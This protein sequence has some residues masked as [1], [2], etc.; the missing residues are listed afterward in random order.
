[1]RYGKWPETDWK[2]KSRKTGEILFRLNFRHFR[3]DKKTGSCKLSQRLLGL[4][5]RRRK[6][7]P[8]ADRRVHSSNPRNNCGTHFGSSS[9]RVPKVTNWLYRHKKDCVHLNFFIATEKVLVIVRWKFLL[10]GDHDKFNSIVRYLHKL[11][12][13]TSNSHRQSKLYLTRELVF[14][15]PLKLS[16]YFAENKKIKETTLFPQKF[17]SKQPVL[18]KRFRRRLTRDI[19][20]K[21]HW[22]FGPSQ[23]EIWEFSPLGK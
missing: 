22:F 20:T 12:I 1:M 10:L 14:S 23:D 13:V 21:N 5:L 2:S 3:N 19:M 11:L 16:L 8:I 7:W 6:K 4:L 17:V 9:L 15:I 18:N